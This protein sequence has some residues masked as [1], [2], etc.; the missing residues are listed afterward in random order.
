ML[1]HT[2]KQKLSIILKRSQIFKIMFCKFSVKVTDI[3]LV[4]KII[5]HNFVDYTGDEPY[6]CDD[7]DE[8]TTVMMMLMMMIRK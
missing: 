4:K 7:Y 3:G 2:T 6:L 5:D 8:M 1:S